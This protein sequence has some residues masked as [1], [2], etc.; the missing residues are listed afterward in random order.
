M[1]KKKLETVRKK[2]DI[3]DLKILNLIKKRTSLVKE[4][5]KLKPLKKQIVDH[6]RINKVLKNIRKKSIQ[7]KIDP[8]ITK[9]IWKSIIWGYIDLQKR[10]FKKK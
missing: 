5:L 1:N 4:I 6:K 2:L 10:S 3:L 8:K 9:K 7:K